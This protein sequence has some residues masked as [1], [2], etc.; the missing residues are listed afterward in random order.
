MEFNPVG[1]HCELPSHGF[2][3][4]VYAPGGAVYAGGPCFPAGLVS[5]HE[6][7]E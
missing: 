3:T 2:H 7:E 1:F 6:M 5:D 4:A